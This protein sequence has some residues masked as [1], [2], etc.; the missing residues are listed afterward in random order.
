MGG[1]NGST[2]ADW[3]PPKEGTSW[4]SGVPVQSGTDPWVDETEDLTPGR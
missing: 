1:A 3:K 4:A 2:A